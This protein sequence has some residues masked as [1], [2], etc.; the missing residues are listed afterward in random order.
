M[1]ANNL[2]ISW[3]QL[4]A[5]FMLVST[6]CLSALF[7]GGSGTDDDPYLIGTAV[8]LDSVRYFRTAVFRQIADIDLGVEPYIQG[9]GWIPFGVYITQDSPHNTQFN[10]KYFGNGYIIRNLYINNL[11]PKHGSLFGICVNATLFNIRVY[12]ANVSGLGSKAIL[13]GGADNCDIINCHTTGAV[14]SNNYAGGLA[15]SCSNS[16][17]YLCSSKCNVLST[18]TAGG[19]LGSSS[20]NEITDCFSTR[21]VGGYG[22][23]GGLVGIDSHSNLSRCHSG[24]DVIAHAKGCGGLVGRPYYTNIDMC[25]TTGDVAGTTC[26]GGIGGHVDYSTISNSFA[27]GNIAGTYLIGGLVGEQCVNSN[28]SKSYSTGTV[29]GLN[30]VGGLVGKRTGA[31]YT[32]YSYWDTVSSG[33]TSSAG[34]EGRTSLEMTFPY[35]D[36]TFINWDL[37]AT[38][39]SDNSGAINDGYPYLYNLPVTESEDDFLPVIQSVSMSNYPNPFHNSTTIRFDLPKSGNINLSIYN[40]K[41]Q[42]I[43]TLDNDFRSKGEHSLVWDGKSD[44]GTAVSSGIYVY[45]LQGQ[46]YKASGKMILKK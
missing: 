31:G 30:N 35:S 39:Q 6:T 22:S 3:K 12:N 44:N 13:C 43:K 21:T 24:S 45:K 27:R 33:L 5:I 19:L 18:S 10:G 9:E 36:N 38:W 26:V 28:V 16:T 4:L 14:N 17:I 37:I 32:S 8:Q 41:G 29:T 40:V 23:V 2:V 42:L 25:Y 11:D 7:S 1:K 20:Y 15:S 34:G 46:G